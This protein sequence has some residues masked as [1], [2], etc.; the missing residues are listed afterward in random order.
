[1]FL[2]INPALWPSTM[3]GLKG[4]LVMFEFVLAVLNDFSL[5]LFIQTNASF[6]AS[7]KC[8]WAKPTSRA[9]LLK[10]CHWHKWACSFVFAKGVG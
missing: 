1:M 4:A 6:V 3:A 8:V 10:V 2:L 5:V 7:T 9:M